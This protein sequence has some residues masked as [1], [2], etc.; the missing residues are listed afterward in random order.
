MDL[1]EFLIKVIVIF[2]VGTFL[3][4]LLFFLSDLLSK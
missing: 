2:S 4:E 1:I 3:L